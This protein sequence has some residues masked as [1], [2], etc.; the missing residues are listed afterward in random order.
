[1]IRITARCDLRH[2][3]AKKSSAPSV[4][5]MNSGAP[6]VLDPNNLQLYEPAFAATAAGRCSWANSLSW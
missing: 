6:R 1:M 2:T 3:E 4:Q 5:A